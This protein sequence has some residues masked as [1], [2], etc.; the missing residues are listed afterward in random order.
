MFP[1]NSFF[2]S[3]SDKVDKPKQNGS[4]DGDDSL[5]GS[6]QGKCVCHWP[7]KLYK[8]VCAGYGKFD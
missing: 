3:L 7:L 8:N 5:Q 6:K 1:L 4:A 2:F